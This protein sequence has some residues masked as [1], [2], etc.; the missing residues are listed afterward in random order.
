M[1][2]LNEEWLTQRYEGI[3]HSKTGGVFGFECLSGWTWLIDGALQLMQSHSK[4]NSLELEIT[5]IKEK[6]GRLRFAYYGGDDCIDSICDITELAS[7][8]I[9]E[10]CGQLGR[11]VLIQGWLS[12]RCD[13]HLTNTGDNGPRC[14]DVA[15]YHGY[16]LAVTIYKI[17]D[18]FGDARLAVKWC[19]TPLLATG[20]VRPC[21]LLGSI[22]G[23]NQI[24]TIIGRLSHS[25]PL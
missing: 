21:E 12:T 2:Q 24:L 3:L 20:R 7:E 15:Q 17:I 5:Q 4:A 19:D 9:C 22:S 25:I 8:C 6:F 1:H 13:S 23:R 18:F 10:I 16:G 11:N 14:T